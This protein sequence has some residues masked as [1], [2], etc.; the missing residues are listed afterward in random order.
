LACFQCCMFLERLTLLGIA[1]GNTK[2]NIMKFIVRTILA[3]VITYGMR[4]VL[5]G[6]SPV[7][8]AR[9]PD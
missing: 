2:G 5:N 4:K 9:V 1:R 6:Q 3:S 8:S 7:D